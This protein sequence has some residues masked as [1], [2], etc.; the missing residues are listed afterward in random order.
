[1][2]TEP[3]PRFAF[4]EAMITVHGL[5]RRVHLMRG[6]NLKEATG[7]RILTE[8]KM[9]N[10]GVIHFCLKKKY[11]IAGSHF[12]DAECSN[13]K[14]HNVSAEAFLD[15]VQIVAGTQIVKY[16]QRLN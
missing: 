1:M 15:A 2:K 13:L 11:Y 12:F 6:F 9:S 8:F 14:M 5:I 16:E 7:S 10:P 3:N 4:I